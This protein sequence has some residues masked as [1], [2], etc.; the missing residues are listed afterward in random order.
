MGHEKLARLPFCMCPCYRI[1]ICIYAMLRTRATFSWPTLYIY[2]Y[3]YMLCFVGLYNKMHK[4]HGTYSKIYQNKK[5][6]YSSIRS[7]YLCT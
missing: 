7:T 1:N 4:M 3:I 2:I 6:D 5:P